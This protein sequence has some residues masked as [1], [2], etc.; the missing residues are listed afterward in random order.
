MTSAIDLRCVPS[1]IGIDPAATSMH[2]SPDCQRSS[3]TLTFDRR[4]GTSL[5][6]Q[7]S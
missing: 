7:N 2:A 1:L 4:T 3:G 5:S 6:I